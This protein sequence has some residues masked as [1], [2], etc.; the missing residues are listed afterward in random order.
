VRDI[1]GAVDETFL[2][3]LMFVFQDVSTGYLLLE[4]VAY[5]RTYTTWQAVVDKRLQ[6]VGTGVLSLVSD[7]A[8]ALIQLAAKGLEHLSIPDFFPL[9]HE[10]VK[11]YALAMGRRLRQAQQDLKH[12]EEVLA[13]RQGLPHASHDT[14]GVCPRINTSGSCRDGW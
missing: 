11:S 8:K 2:A 13:R 10:I 7:R 9:V 14:L 5:D 1:L 12:A 6:D 4:V 3:H